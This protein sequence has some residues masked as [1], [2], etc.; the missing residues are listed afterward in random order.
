MGLLPF[1]L[2]SWGT[3]DIGRSRGL[4]LLPPHRPAPHLSQHL[5]SHLMDQ[6]GMWLFGVQGSC[7]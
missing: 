6:L 3:K 5:S 2:P 1:L 4:L 7:G